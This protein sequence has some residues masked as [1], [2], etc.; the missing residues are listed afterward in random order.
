[1]TAE[2]KSDFI[3]ACPCCGAQ[4]TIDTQLQ[5]V[6]AH[7]APAQKHHDAPDLDHAGEL[8]RQQKL[9]REAL[10]Q[11][12]TEDEKSKAQLL[13]RKFAEALKKSKDEP[14]TRPQRDIDL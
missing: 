6:I 3:V 9:R 11:Q 10:F 7:E 14:V 2:R 13:E 8:L 1:M 5:K 12:S 4:L